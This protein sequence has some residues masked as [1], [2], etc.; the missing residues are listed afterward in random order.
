MTATTQYK[1]DKSIVFYFQVHQP[2]CLKKLQFFDVGSHEDYFDDRLNERMLARAARE[3]YL[4]INMTLLELIKEH[5]MVRFSFSISGVTLDQFEKY[6]PEV[7]D[8]FSALSDT[9]AVEFLAE[10]NYH[11]LASLIS[12]EEFQSQILEHAQKIHHHF[13]VHPTIL[14]NT[15]LIYNDAIGTTASRLGFNGV[16]CDDVSGI[17]N[18]G[19]GNTVYK[20]PEEHDLKIFLRNN[21]LSNDIGGGRVDGNSYL[22]VDDYC[23]WLYDVPGNNAVIFL[24]L[25]YGVF[26]DREKR[27][28]AFGLLKEIIERVSDDRILEMVTPSELSKTAAPLQSLSVK[29]TISGS[30]EQDLAAWLGNDM[31]MEAFEAI[32]ELNSSIKETGSSELADIWRHLQTSDHF[33]YMS[34]RTNSDGSHHYFS[35]YSSPY[36]AFI[37]Y[38]NIVSDF[39]L[40]VKETPV[41]TGLTEQARNLEYERQHTSPPV[42]A[43][44]H[45]SQYKQPS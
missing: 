39:K 12:E 40:L 6:T 2:R 24:G 35:H 37:N 44:H 31:Q 29:E 43:L 38:M 22:T 36:E 21:R 10:T 7:I 3:Y 30:G 28:G 23:S 4:P 27:R 33:Y 16:I 14:K 20:H 18:S 1:S 26:G 42:W 15:E 13:G 41:Q 11:S 34:T 5:P 8:S 19:S 9:G 45:Q 17:L 32:K 25:D